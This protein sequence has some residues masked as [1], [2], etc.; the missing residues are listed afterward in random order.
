MKSGFL[1]HAEEYLKESILKKA[2]YIDELYEVMMVKKCSDTHTENL[3]RLF[4][5]F[6]ISTFEL[7]LRE[8]DR[9][10]VLFSA[11]KESMDIVCRSSISAE[12]KFQIMD[13]VEIIDS[14]TFLLDQIRENRISEKLID[15]LLKSANSTS[16]YFLNIIFLFRVNRPY[17]KSKYSISMQEMS[18]KELYYSI[19]SG[20]VEYEEE[21]SVSYFR[22][23]DIFVKSAYKKGN[24]MSN[25]SVLYFLEK[26]VKDG[27]IRDIN[28]ILNTVGNF[29]D[30]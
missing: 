3:K 14:L 18:A 5:S 6:C 19:T 16:Y 30:K 2:A 11:L 26:L 20:Y 4:N 8:S 22:F 25:D 15:S 7:G 21:K 23:I 9:I 29:T 24:D 28:P 12:K 10:D 17:V 1:F 13:E 27:Y